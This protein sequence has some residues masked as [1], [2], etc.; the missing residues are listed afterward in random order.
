MKN[1]KFTPLRDQE[2]NM[3]PRP[4]TTDQI[5]GV[6]NSSEALDTKMAKLNDLRQQHDDWA[7]RQ[8][9]TDGKPLLRYID[10][11]VKRLL[12]E[13]DIKEIETAS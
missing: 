8:P 13:G 4:V 2:I 1:K 12:H 11:A 7:N 6:V 10:E 5:D 9:E 3:E